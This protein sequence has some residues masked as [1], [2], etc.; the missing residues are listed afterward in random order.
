MDITQ[1]PGQ[2]NDSDRPAGKAKPRG[3]PFTGKDDSRLRQNIEAARAAEPEQGEAAGQ[4]DVSLYEATKHVFSRPKE[5][6]RTQPQRECRAWL[7][8][9]RKGFLSRLAELEKAALAKP[10]KEGD[11]RGPDGLLP[12]RATEEV[13]NPLIDSL[14]GEAS[15]FLD[16]DPGDRSL[17]I[18]RGL[19]GSEGDDRWA[20]TAEG[21]RVLGLPAAA[22]GR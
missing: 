22:R 19:V 4:E 3:R 14:L 8:D 6:D 12:D 15:A 20:L 11:E 16:L 10:G 9:D 5:A 18:E 7:K 21:R 17:L 2:Q 1:Q 13:I